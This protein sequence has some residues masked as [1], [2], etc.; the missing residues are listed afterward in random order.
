MMAQSVDGS[1]GSVS[2]RCGGGKREEA[3]SIH[4]DV[5]LQCV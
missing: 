2:L 1:G 5:C 3:Y 4:S